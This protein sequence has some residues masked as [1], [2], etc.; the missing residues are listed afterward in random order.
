M[1]HLE[2]MQVELTAASQTSLEPGQPAE[3][4]RAYDCNRILLV[5]GGQGTLRLE[6][7]TEELLPGVCSI[8]QAGVPHAVEADAKGTLTYKWCHFRASYT[9][10]ELYRI[11]RIPHAV[12]FEPWGEPAAL[13][14]GIASWAVKSALTS[15]LRIKAALLELISL[16]LE[17]SEFVLSDVAPSPEMVKIE[18]VL[19]YIDAHLADSITVEELAGLVYLHPNY[20]I[21]FF[22]G[23]MGCSPIQYVNQR[24]MET[25]RALL[26][27]PDWNVSD[28]AA[29]I[30]M[31]IYYFSRMF[32]AHTG[33]TPSRYRKLAASGSL[34]T[35]VPGQAETAAAEESAVRQEKPAS[36][37]EKAA[38]RAE[39]TAISE[40]RRARQEELTDD[41]HE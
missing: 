39:R 17:H 34:G 16:Y 6:E 25:A 10:R 15:R 19:R 20:F 38:G 12:R 30:G 37:D 40:E 8:L 11:L 31:K 7:R 23:M 9:D 41:R 33:L 32:K 36:P 18:S 5:T 26:A 3:E 24:R 4:S 2:H 29:S 13:L 35:G 21:V 22:K 14:D 28:V 1:N 27:Q